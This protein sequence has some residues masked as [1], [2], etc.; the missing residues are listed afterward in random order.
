MAP[1][2]CG[3]RRQES[4]I[5]GLPDLALHAAY[6]EKLKSREGDALEAANVA[7]QDFAHEGFSIHWREFRA[8]ML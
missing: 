7:S 6:C 4:S 5:Q 3:N 8:Q 2:A 1:G